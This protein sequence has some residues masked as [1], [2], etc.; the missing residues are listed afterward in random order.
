MLNTDVFNNQY[1]LYDIAVIYELID[2]LIDYFI[3][4]SI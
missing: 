1:D 4:I 2:W 3:D